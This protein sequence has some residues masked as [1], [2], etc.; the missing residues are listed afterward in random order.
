MQGV[1]KAGKSK[2]VNGHV[3]GVQSVSSSS[4]KMGA[5]AIQEDSNRVIEVFVFP[6]YCCWNFKKGGKMR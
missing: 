5:A 6:L 4:Q 2:V 3:R 1:E